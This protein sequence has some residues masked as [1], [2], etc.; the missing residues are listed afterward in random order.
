M[1][2]DPFPSVFYNAPLVFW[3]AYMQ[4]IQG[5]G[6]VTMPQIRDKSDPVIWQFFLL[7]LTKNKLFLETGSVCKLSRDTIESQLFENTTQTVTHHTDYAPC[8]AMHR[9]YNFRATIIWYCKGIKTKQVFH[10]LSKTIIW[11]F[12]KNTPPPLP[13]PHL[14]L[15][16]VWK[17]DMFCVLGLALVEQKYVLSDDNIC[18]HNINWFFFPPD[19]QSFARYFSSYQEEKKSYFSIRNLN[20]KIHINIFPDL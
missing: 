9:H 3:S 5:S 17:Q 15:I 13:S 8:M 12:V 18:R 7:L 2:F 19:I 11:V 6:G 16:L 10:F 20:N 1:I 14:V 4:R